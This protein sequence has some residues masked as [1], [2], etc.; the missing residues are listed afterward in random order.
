MVVFGASLPGQAHGSCQGAGAG[1]SPCAP[2]L[3]IQAL[4][5][6]WR[7]EQRNVELGSVSSSRTQNTSNSATGFTFSLLVPFSELP[8]RGCSLS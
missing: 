8:V 4:D 1:R 5:I 7:K 3:F 6:A 2:A